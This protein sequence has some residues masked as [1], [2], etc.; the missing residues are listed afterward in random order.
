MSAE[1]PAPQLVVGV[2]G[3]AEEAD[4]S[5]ARIGREKSGHRA[6][7]RLMAGEAYV[8]SLEALEQQEGIERRKRGPR[9]AAPDRPAPG[10]V[11]GIREVSGVAHAVERRLGLGHAGETLG[12]LGP[13]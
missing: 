3:K 13:R 2:V 5:D 8:E 9:V 11:R 6:G 7:V 12:V 10:H 4:P 1:I